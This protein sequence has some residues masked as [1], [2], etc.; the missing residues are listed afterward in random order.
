MNTYSRSEETFHQKKV[1]VNDKFDGKCGNDVNQFYGNS[2]SFEV[3]EIAEVLLQKPSVEKATEF[4]SFAG[5]LARERVNQI[6]S[7]SR[8]ACIFWRFPTTR[9]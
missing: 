8:R 2:V 9:R 1:F 6:L 5:R 7:R 3:S 4:R